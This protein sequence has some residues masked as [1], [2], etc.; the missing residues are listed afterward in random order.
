MVSPSARRA[1]ESGSRRHSRA[2][3]LS[4]V[5]SPRAAKIG[6]ASANL[7]G[8]GLRVGVIVWHRHSGCE[9]KILLDELRLVAPTCIVVSKRFR[10]PLKRNAIETGFRDSDHRAPRC[11][12]KQE[13]NQGGVF[14]RI[15]EP[16]IDRARMPAEGEQAHW[17]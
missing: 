8:I 10:A 7:P 3:S 2:T 6:A 13:L 12:F 4:R 15:V 17:F 11:L 9:R 5:S 14:I 1:I 16:G